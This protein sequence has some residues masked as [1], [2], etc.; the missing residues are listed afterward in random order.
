MSPKSHFQEL[1][2]SIGGGVSSDIS[3]CATT[4]P[5]QI[6][7]A[8]IANMTKRYSIRLLLADGAH[9]G[10]ADPSGHDGANSI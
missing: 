7:A 2:M 5:G 3:S 6:K 10:H 9:I 1:I 8:A 4:A